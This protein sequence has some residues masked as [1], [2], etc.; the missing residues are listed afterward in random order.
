MKPTYMMQWNLSYQRQL[1]SNWLLTLN[2]LGNGTRHIWGAR[3]I[4]PAVFVPGTCTVSGK[5]SACSTVANTN[6]RRVLNSLNPS[7]GKL[8]SSIVEADDGGVSNYNG[9]LVSVQHRFAQHFTVLAN[10]TW[11]HCISDLDFQGELAGTLYQD[12]NYRSGDRANCIY[13]HRSIFNTSLVALSGGLGS[14]FLKNL[15][16]NWELALIITASSGAPFTVT[17]GTDV[18]LTGGGHDR[19]NQVLASAVPSNQTITSWINPAAFHV[20]PAG[21]FGN[22]GRDSVNMP[23]SWDMDSA[24]SR[25]FKFTERWN[26]DA[27]AD[28]FNVLNHGNWLL[29][30]PGTTTQAITSN[31][32]GQVTTFG[33]PRIIQLGMKLNF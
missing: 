7:Q 13:D 27:R 10:Y 23:G 33:D 28:I 1:S 20:Q 8:Y 26:L 29:F 17:D 30:T 12:Q 14:G 32:F 11:S 22:A 3:D 5:T 15:T 21:T 6:Q 25:I 2:Y 16:N 18:S 4:N 19:P 9:L 31:T 24:V